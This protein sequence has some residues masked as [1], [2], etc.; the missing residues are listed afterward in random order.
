MPHKIFSPLLPLPVSK[1]EREGVRGYI[2]DES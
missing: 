2:K 1:G